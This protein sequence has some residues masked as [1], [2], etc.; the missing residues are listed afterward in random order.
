MLAKKYRLRK[1]TEFVATYAQKQDVSNAYITLNLGKQKPFEDFITKVAFVVSKKV[2]KMSEISVEFE[3][4]RNENDTLKQ[5]HIQIMEEMKEISDAD[6]QITDSVAKL[7]SDSVADLKK[8]VDN[9]AGDSLMA[10]A[11]VEPLYPHLKSEPSAKSFKLHEKSIKELITRV[12]IAKELKEAKEKEAREKKIAM[13]SRFGFEY[14]N[15]CAL[16]E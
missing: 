5:K 1:N 6:Q 3:L 2:D 11:S 10:A 15:F 12:K 7:A 4:V 14:V 16:G 8:Q 13:E 9:L